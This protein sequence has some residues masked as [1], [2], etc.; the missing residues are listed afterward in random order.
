ML[1]ACNKDD[2][3]KIEV[4]D[5]RLI[6][7]SWYY[8]YNSDSA[9]YTFSDNRA[10]YEYMDRYIAS[11]GQKIDHGSYKITTDRII[12]RGNDKGKIY[13]LESNTLYIKE[14]GDDSSY[15]PYSKVN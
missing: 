7:G 6:E 9:V 5:N 10:V 13:K 12:F 8:I 14:G 1:F 2:D 3:E 4:L 15:I 11:G